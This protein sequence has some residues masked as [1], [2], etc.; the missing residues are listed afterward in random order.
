MY[1]QQF[2]NQ[3]YEPTAQAPVGVPPQGAG[4]EPKEIER[5]WAAL[6]N[7]WN[8]AILDSVET[9]LQWATNMRWK[10]ITPLVQCVE[11]TYQRG[12]R[13]LTQELEDY[14]PFWQRSE[15]LP[16][17]DITIVPG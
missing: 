11:T 10:G 12:V 16:K 14:L 2:Q 5:C 13:V 3:R 6:E 17:W 8:G 15:T 1:C 4:N 9:A 7:Y